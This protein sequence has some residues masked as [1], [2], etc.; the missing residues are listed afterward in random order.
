MKA[1]Y[2]IKA[3]GVLAN[4]QN[5]YEE[6]LANFKQALKADPANEDA[7]YNYEMVKKKLEEQSKHLALL[8]KEISQV[9]MNLGLQNKKYLKLS[10]SRMKLEEA[11][12]VSK[13]NTDFDAQEG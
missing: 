13:K 2:A 10:E 4:Q 5:K 1:K 9:E 8:N 12:S 11:L 3:L 6:A 7:R